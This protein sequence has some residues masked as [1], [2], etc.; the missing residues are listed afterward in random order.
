MVGSLNPSLLPSGVLEEFGMDC[1]VL[2]KVVVVV[3]L[4]DKILSFFLM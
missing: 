2:K 1:W 4:V 3:L